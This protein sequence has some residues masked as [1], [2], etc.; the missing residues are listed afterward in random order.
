VRNPL[1]HSIRLAPNVRAGAAQDEIWLCEGWEL[2]RVAASAAETPEQLE[3]LGPTFIAAQVPGT[4]ASAD[5]DAASS[6]ELDAWDHWYRCSFP[7]PPE[8]P[9][10]RSV[11]CLDGLATLA[12]VFLNGRLLVHSTNMFEALSCDV[13]SLLES[14]NQLH[15]RFRALALRLR[16]RGS[17]GR[18][19]TLLVSERNLRFVRTT[20]LGYM[21]AFGPR[22]RPVGPW[23]GVRLVVQKQLAI[24][25]V[26]L[27]AG[28]DGSRGVLDVAVTCRVLGEGARLTRAEVTA[29][30]ARGELAV[31]HGD[32]GCVLH[33]RLVVDDVVAWWPHTHGTA[34]RYDV[35]V[36]V[37]TDTAPTTLEL[38]R[39][40]FRSLELDRQAG[41]GFGLRL[42]GASVFC[43]GACWTPL[44]LS[45]LHG[46][47]QAYRAALE[48]VR[49]GGMNMLRVP[50]TTIYESDTFYELCDELGVL[51][52]QDFM[53][54]NMDYPVE[55]PQF[56][57]SCRREAVA[58]L[59]RMSGRACLSML[60]GNSEVAQ[61]AA[62]MGMGP[63]T[64]SNA[65][66]DR[67]LPEVCAERR[68][69]V[70]YV[71]STPSGGD[72]PFHTGPGPSH[73]YGVGAYLR[74]IEDAELRPVRFATECLAFSNPPE[75]DSLRTWLGDAALS[76]HGER[77]RERIPRDQGADWDFADV[78][79]HYVKALFGVEARSLRDTDPDRYLMLARVAPAEAMERV[80]GLWRRR[81]SGCNGAL[82]W[83]L[84]DLWQSAGLGVIDSSGVPKA[85]YYA[86][87]RAWAPLAL[88]FVDRGT[89]G[90]AL[91]AANDRPESV[92]AELELALHRH[93]GAVVEHLERQIEIGAG[94]ELVL[95]V[96]GLLGHFVDASYAYRFGSPG[97]AL[98]TARLV[99]G[100]EG[101]GREV[102]ARAFH[103]P[104]GL[105]HDPDREV[106]LGAT[107]RAVQGGGYAVTVTAERFAQSVHFSASGYRPS[108][109]YF[110]VAPRDAHVV[111]LT[112]ALDVPA[113]LLHG[114]LR[115]VN[116]RTP[117][118]I[119]VEQSAERP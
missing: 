56:V 67:V 95:T 101:A 117:V 39:V 119:Q 110:H 3:A 65:L 69:D 48:Q 13:S 47:E 112:P 71:S 41:E 9:N 42:N 74:P 96:E 70:P 61:Q 91:Y 118:T 27:V 107:A 4:V 100:A 109:D 79:D 29:G 76:V 98:V 68:P 94:S 52:W 77:Y 5:L 82:V 28:L 46:S 97:H 115:A 50:G 1:R 104:L 60:C 55:D 33:G 26:S 38:G 72:L 66:F 106:G 35:R 20:L 23:R 108:D 105:A 92:A 86:L 57:E 63:D 11:L 36:R 88:W 99:R 83:F 45:A 51:V 87:R 44:D 78:T 53:F 17:R 16:E 21:P 116:S 73:Y 14:R 90:L 80:Q 81:T 84:R 18:W 113:G 49:A 30:G 102:L 64:W 58:F 34:H 31:K 24:E 54:A 25:D 59:Q 103:L 10:G 22:L 62:M 15:I 114:T 2:A 8:A 75:D 40:G 7:R 85:P 89:D 111:L 19:P 12:D 93:D 32:G 6:L 43:R 37:E